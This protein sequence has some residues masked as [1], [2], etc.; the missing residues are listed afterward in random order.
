MTTHYYYLREGSTDLKCT[1]FHGRSDGTRNNYNEPVRYVDIPLTNARF[2]LLK[3]YNNPADPTD[4]SDR[5]GDLIIEN[6]DDEYEISRVGLYYIKEMKINHFRR[7][8]SRN[9]TGLFPSER[10]FFQPSS[11]NFGE[12]ACRAVLAKWQREQEVLTSGKQNPYFI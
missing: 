12:A 9:A 5:V 10:R 8:D 2:R 4:N 1:I 7:F 3:I 6:G 11:M